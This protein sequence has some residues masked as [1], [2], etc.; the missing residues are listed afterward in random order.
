MR[1]ANEFLRA[2]VRAYNFC[3]DI[4]N[5][6]I[7]G[8]YARVREVEAIEIANLYEQLPTLAEGIG[9]VTAYRALRL[10]IEQQ[11]KFATKVLGIR[12]EPTLDNPYPNSEA[13]CQDVRENKR[14]KVYA[15]ELSHPYLTDDEQLHFRF[16]HDL[17]GHATEGYQFGPRG[18]QNAWIHHSMMFS[19]L[20]QRALTTETRG[21]N[22]W[23]NYGPY[24]S[25]PVCD[26]PFAPQKA[27]LLPA[28]CC[29]WQAAMSQED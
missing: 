7:E 26:R 20:A 1:V 29:D 23:V 18:E 15:S 9:T 12:C 28:W 10:E 5:Q 11:Y 14:L 22:S 3:Y 25:L 16:V 17:F 8:H 19:A 21:Q 13:M 6:V 24:R 4:P 2:G 27:A